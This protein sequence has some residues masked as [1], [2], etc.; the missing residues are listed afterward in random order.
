MEDQTINV[1][2]VNPNPNLVGWIILTVSLTIV[3][4]VL[5]FLWIFSLTVVD[6]PCG[7]TGE[8]GVQINTAA[9]PQR[10]CGTSRDMPCMFTVSSLEECVNICNQL[11]NICSGFTYNSTTNTMTIVNPTN[12]Y[13]MSQTNLYI[14]QI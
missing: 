5:L 7:C 12:T 8:F 6:Q 14:R 4:I 9:R 3:I 13:N 1:Y 11:V 2:R 10:N